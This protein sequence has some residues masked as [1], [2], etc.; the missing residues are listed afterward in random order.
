[1]RLNRILTAH[2]RKRPKVACDGRAGRIVVAMITYT[3]TRGTDR[4]AADLHGGHP[5]GH[6]AGRRAVRAAGAAAIGAAELR[7]TGRASLCGAGG[8]GLR[9]LRPRRERR[10]HPSHLLHRLRRQLRPPAG[11]SGARPRRRSLRARA[12]ARS[13]AGLQGHG[14]AV[15][16]ALLQPGAG[17]GRMQSG[18]SQ[19][20][21]LIL[22]ATSGDTGVAAL[23]GFADRAHTRIVVY[24]P[25]AG[26]SAVQ[27]RQMVTQP[28]DNLSVFRLEGDFDACQT[29]VKAVFDDR[30]LRRRAGRAAPAGA[31]LGQLHQLGPP[32][33]PDRL[34]PERL[35]RPARRRP[36]PGRRHWSTSACPPAT[37]ATSW[38]ATTPGAWARPSAACSAPATP[39]TCWPTSSPRRTY[40]I[41]SRSL[42]KTPSPS[43]DILVSSNLERLLYDLSGRPGGD[44]GLDEASCAATGRFAVDA[45]TLRRLQAEFAGDWV[46]NAE[47]LRTIG[48]VYREHGLPDGPAHR[49]RLA[50]RRAA[51]GRRARPRRRYGPL[52]QVRR[53]RG[54]RAH[55]RRRRRAAAGRRRRARPARPRRRAGARHRACR[56]SWRP[57]ASAPCA[58]ASAWPAAREA[59]EESLRRWLSSSA[60]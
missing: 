38:P 20:D 13:H 22:V 35:R 2:F 50:R 60:S 10:P 52:E 28:G 56:R 40:D 7:S 55:R 34:L 58:S 19:L 43:M 1:M 44:P 24:Y 4:P 29:A 46:D 51:Q 25:D 23:N 49:R 14:A 18:A 17:A 59:L 11:R 32:A 57:C 33:A 45:E 36:P 47:C 39:T 3:D 27:E 12:L 5:G 26:V 31:Q 53:R 9:G 15:H 16:A 54:A 30:G 21:Y 41:S 37:S 48:E 42:V 8:A 6:R